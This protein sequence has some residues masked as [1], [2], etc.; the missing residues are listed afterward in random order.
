MCTF[1]APE[2]ALITASQFH[3]KIKNSTAMNTHQLAMRVGINSGPVV[4][5]SNSVYG[6]T[7]NIAARLA[8]QAKANQSLVASGTILSIKES[9]RDQLRPVGRISLQGKAG[10]IEVHELLEPGSEEEITEVA[11]TNEIVSRSF[12]MTARYQS[13]QMRFDPMLVRFL[14]GRSVD[15][16][17]VINHPTVSR[18]HAEFL[19]RNGQFIFRD[20]SSNGSTVVQ[21]EKTE[22]LHRSSFELRGVGKIYLGR[23]L[24]FP[25]HCIKFT[26][27]TSR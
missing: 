4:S 25:Q 23:T 3:S 9:L 27:I 13:R 21:G 24:G 22:K 14:F 15:C 2:E 5:V 19:Y 10:A 8:Q 7:V 11:T 20:F 6:D 1:N 26:C 17:Q 16:D 18:E 12:L